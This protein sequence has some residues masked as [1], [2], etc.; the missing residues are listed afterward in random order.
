M[1]LINSIQQTLRRYDY[2][3]RTA[4]LSPA[5]LI[6]VVSLCGVFFFFFS[7]SFSFFPQRLSLTRVSLSL[8]LSLSPASD[9]ICYQIIKTAFYQLTI[10]DD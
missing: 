9:I 3:S 7:F 5:M 6:I 8:S 10:T 2:L 1:L 4:P